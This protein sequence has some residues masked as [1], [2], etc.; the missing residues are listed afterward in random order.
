MRSPPCGGYVKH[1]TAGTPPGLW[2][3]MIP[4]EVVGTIIKPVALALRLFAN[5]TAGHIL[6]AVLFMFAVSGIGLIKEGGATG[7]TL[8]PVITVVSAVAAVAI[9]FLELFVAFLQAFVFMFLTTVFISQ[10][11][12]HGDH[13]PTAGCQRL[14]GD[15]GDHIVA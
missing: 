7:Y 1:L 13:A 4:I 11:S 14:S 2:A 10:L 12:H 3:L 6:V 15:S 5:M 9:Y 8:G